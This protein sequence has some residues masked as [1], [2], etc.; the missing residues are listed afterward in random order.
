LFITHDLAVARYMC[1]RIAVMYLGQIV[2][3]GL[4]QQ[5]LAKPLHPYTQALISAVPVDRP[6][7]PRQEVQIRGEIP[8]AT[9][10]FP[11]CGFEPR[12]SFAQTRCGDESP[13]LVEIDHEH[14]A[15]CHLAKSA[16][17]ERPG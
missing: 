3:I 11:G 13:L 8:S 17:S 5:V 2:E 9:F 15:A 10:D 1:D 16:R 12:C 7:D 4:R 6:D 14:F